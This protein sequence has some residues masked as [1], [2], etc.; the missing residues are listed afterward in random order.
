M[1]LKKATSADVAELAGVSKWT[2]I[3]AF[4]HGASISHGSRELV[5]KAADK[6]DYRPNLLARSL[7]TKKT[8][9]VAVLIDDFTNLHK[10]PLLEKLSLALQDEGMVLMLININKR[11][12]QVDAL[13]HANQ[14]QVDGIILF[15]NSLQD[16]ILQEAKSEKINT[17]LIILGRESTVPSVP[18]VTTDSRRSMR[19]IGEHLLSRG[20]RRPGFMTG[21]SAQA[22]LVTRYH[23]YRGFWRQHGVLNIPVLP[24]GGYDRMQGEAALRSYLNSAPAKRID[25][26]MCEN[27]NLAFGT[28][29]VAR[30]EF[31]LNVPR[32]L[33]VVGYDG[34]DMSGAQSYGLTTYLQPLDR[35]VKLT[36]DI[37]RGRI[38]S[39]SVRV[40][41][42]L[43]VRSTT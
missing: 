2:V 41:G 8:N 38:P 7:A 4:T 35:M 31:G 28:L 9:Q 21:P 5:L 20:Y 34:I 1:N 40:V 25:V 6:L 19:E 16:E 43:L 30:V 15:A 32:D 13:I 11:F 17:P 14:R 24:A 12:A 33:S 39:K 10:L 26:L 36:V 29:D 3:R 42:K 37:L 23:H 18:S 22:S 27:D